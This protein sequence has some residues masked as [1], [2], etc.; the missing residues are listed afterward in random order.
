[1]ALWPKTDALYASQQFHEHLLARRPLIDLW[2]SIGGG[3]S[4]PYQRSLYADALAH[5][6]REEEALENLGQSLEQIER[7]GWDERVHLAEILRIKGAVLEHKGD[8]EGAEYSYRDSLE[9][10]RKQQAKSWEL[11]TSTSLAHLWQSQGRRKEAR[12]LLAPIYDWFT[13]GFDTKDLKEAKALLGKLN[14]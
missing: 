8:T 13:E 4:L 14:A 12:E 9:W 2:N 7:P 3:I 11:R 10:A 6:G 1:M 5:L